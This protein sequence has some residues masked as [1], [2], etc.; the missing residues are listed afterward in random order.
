MNR[1]IEK[2]L[3]CVIMDESGGIITEVERVSDME[4]EEITPDF[5]DNEKV[6]LFPETLTV[7]LETLNFNQYWINKLLNRK[8]KRRRNFNNKYNKFIKENYRGCS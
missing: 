3:K 2:I 5:V 6:C 1:P 8:V 7:E 4:I